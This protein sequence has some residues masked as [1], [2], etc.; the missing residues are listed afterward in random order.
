MRECA[1]SGTV[2]IHSGLVNIFQRDSSELGS[3]L[4]LL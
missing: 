1:G 4:V 3:A 2:I